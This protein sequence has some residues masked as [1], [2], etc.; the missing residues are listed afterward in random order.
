M[1]IGLY[2]LVGVRNTVGSETLFCTVWQLTFLKPFFCL[3]LLF[4]SGD[5]KF[6][7][8]IEAHTVEKETGRESVIYLSLK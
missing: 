2:I 5:S 6:T 1:L 3:V 8:V 4:E 7:V